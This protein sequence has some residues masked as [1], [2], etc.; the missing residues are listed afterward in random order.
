VGRLNSL[1][2]A[3]A[4]HLLARPLSVRPLNRAGSPTRVALAPLRSALGVAVPEVGF[5]V[6]SA[7]RGRSDGGGILFR[8]GSGGWCRP[9]VGVCLHL[10]LFAYLHGPACVV[11]FP[12]RKRLAVPSDLACSNLMQAGRRGWISDAAPL[13]AVLIYKHRHTGS[14]C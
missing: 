1:G 9:A 10:Y 13:A 2:R 8:S 11:L 7:S 3:R 6:S 12:A 14:P 5:A 4:F